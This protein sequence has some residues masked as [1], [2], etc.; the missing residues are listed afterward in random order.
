MNRL[1]VC[2]CLWHILLLDLLCWGA[3]DLVAN[4]WINAALL[5]VRMN[6][7]IRLLLFLL[8]CRVSF[9]AD[10][11]TAIER[12]LNEQYTSLQT[13]DVR[14]RLVHNVPKG[15]KITPEMLK[16]TPQWEWVKSGS[17][18]LIAREAQK[19]KISVPGKDRFYRIWRCF[20][21]DK[22]IDVRFWQTDPTRVDAV[23]YTKSMS[24]RYFAE[25]Q[26]RLLFGFD[27]F[28]VEY[29]VLD[30][31]KSRNSNSVRDLGEDAVE[32]HV[33]QKV[34]FHEV[35]VGGIVGKT[36]ATV[37]F[38]K[39][40]DWLPRK[41]WTVPKRWVE[42]AN[43]AKRD[44][45][46][47]GNPPPAITPTIEPGEMFGDLQVAE[48]IQV[49]DPILGRKRWFPSRSFPLEM[50][51]AGRP[52][53]SVTFIDSVVVNSPI[54][55]SRF[56]PEESLGTVYEDQRIAGPPAQR[57]VGGNDGT[58]VRIQMSEIESLDPRPATQSSGSSRM[59]SSHSNSPIDAREKR[60]NWSWWMI[61]TGTAVVALLLLRRRIAS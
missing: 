31:L 25:A 29:G 15:E 48:F 50:A 7:I 55:D 47:K 51:M 19:T 39:Q 38:D 2:Y 42:I 57:I 20:D 34:E 44:S 35:N 9:A 23:V 24:P 54:D 43:D 13:I 56:V 4:Q 26:P 8:F 17:K 36:M 10:A 60:S 61:L 1:S 5:G 16:A 53:Y 30:L 21:G 45:K 59:V 27:V 58:A 6:N 14:F 11:L 32:G 22:G 18:L 12:S 41:V 46:A 33:C 40:A 3:H 37:W 52:V 49:D 28:G